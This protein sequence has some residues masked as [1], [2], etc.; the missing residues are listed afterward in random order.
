M[1]KVDGVH[2][3]QERVGG[4]IH[5]VPNWD[6]QGGVCVYVCV[7]VVLGGGEGTLPHKRGDWERGEK[8]TA[9]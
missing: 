4:E 2:S 7:C 9:G 1:R 6:G 3:E 8:L 5:C